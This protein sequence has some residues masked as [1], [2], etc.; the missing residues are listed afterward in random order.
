MTSFSYHQKEAFLLASER[1]KSS[2]CWSTS[3]RDIL[4]RQIMLTNTDM[5]KKA[6]EEYLERCSA[7]PFEKGSIISNGNSFYF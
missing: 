6:L 7:S 2:E 3:D 5:L 1:D 4:D